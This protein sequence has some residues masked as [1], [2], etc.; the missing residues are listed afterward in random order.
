[1]ANQRTNCNSNPN[2]DGENA[3]ISSVFEQHSQQAWTLALSIVGRLADAEEVLQKSLLK[4]MRKAQ[5]ETIIHPG[6]YL[7]AVVRTTA[8][9]LL[10]SR[11]TQQLVIKAACENQTHKQQPHNPSDLMQTKESVAKLERAIAQLPRRYAQ[12]IIGRDIQQQSYAELAQELGISPT[13]ARIYRWKAL[14]RLRDILCR[15]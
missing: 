11:R 6:A 3:W 4:L 10:A 5:K 15:D 2:S 1:M 8:L 9:D 12:V 13:T 14:R 7:R